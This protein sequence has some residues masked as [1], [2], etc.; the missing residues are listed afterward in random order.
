MENLCEIWTTGKSVQYFDPNEP[1]EGVVPGFPDDLDIAKDGSV[2]WSDLM[3]PRPTEVGIGLMTDTS[4]RLIKY[5]A[6]TKTNSVLISGLS[7]ANGVQL[8]SK[9]D[10][11][12]VNESNKGRTLR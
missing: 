1:I 6:K 10:F 8:S 12:L 5:D 2:Y 9:E 11:V 3:A 4:G 7:I